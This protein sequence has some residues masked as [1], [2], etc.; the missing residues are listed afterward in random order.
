[1]PRSDRDGVGTAADKSWY[2]FKYY[3]PRTA[4]DPHVAFVQGYRRAVAD[5]LVDQFRFGGW[6][7]LTRRMLEV[8]EEL[9]VERDAVR[10]VDSETGEVSEETP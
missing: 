10:H 9:T 6:D 3:H 5:M 4:E 8:F 1:M 7:T 2:T